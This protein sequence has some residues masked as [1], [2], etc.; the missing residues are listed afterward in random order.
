MELLMPFEYQI[1]VQP[2]AE[3][4]DDAVP[5]ALT[6]RVVN[7]DDLLKIVERV[8]ALGVLPPGEVAE[9]SIGLKLLTEVSLRHRRDPLFADLW[10]QMSEFMKKLKS[11][12][13]A[14]A[15]VP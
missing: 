5:T 1:T 12:P 14:D 8:Q 13:A 9:F 7:H 15:E 4:L 11:T 6:F 10:P 2:L 3:Q